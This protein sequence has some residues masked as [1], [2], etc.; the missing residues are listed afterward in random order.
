[1]ALYMA[2]ICIGSGGPSS[3]FL[4]MTLNL[5]DAVNEKKD[6]PRNHAAARRP[7]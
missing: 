5:I 4:E 7:W 6:E 1:M 2:A 3:L